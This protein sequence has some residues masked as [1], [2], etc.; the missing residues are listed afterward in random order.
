[1]NACGLFSLMMG[2]HPPPPSPPLAAAKSSEQKQTLLIEKIGFSPWAMPGRAQMAPI[3]RAVVLLGMVL[4]HWGEARNQ[5]HA[6][7]F[8]SPDFATLADAIATMSNGD[9]DGEV[10]ALP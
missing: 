9:G 4:M 3:V 8:P 7:R 6:L 2:G 10:L 1:M 5:K